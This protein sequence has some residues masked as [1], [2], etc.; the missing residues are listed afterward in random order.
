MTF[1]ERLQK[2]HPE[3]C[4][5]KY[6]GGTKLCPFAYGYEMPD[7]WPCED[8]SRDLN[9]CPCPDCWDREIPGTEPTKQPTKKRSVFIS[10]PVTGVER[11][12]EAFEAAMDELSAAGFIP[13]TPSWQP[14]GLTNAQ[15]MRIC[16]AMIDTADAVLF[17]PNWPLSKGARLER[18]YCN[19]TEK[20]YAES[21]DELKEVLGG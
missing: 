1:R 21:V 4:G 15:Y 16:L 7:V 5:N 19:Y 14:Q 8:N 12:Y 11:Y 6:W 18:M 2:E 13:L 10:G 17:L 3:D 20:P 9:K